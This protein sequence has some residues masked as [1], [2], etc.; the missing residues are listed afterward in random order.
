MAL[1]AGINSVISGF[2]SGIS[3]YY[4]RDARFFRVVIYFI[5]IITHVCDL[6]T[7]RMR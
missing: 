5:K 2:L 1:T 4:Y 7:H 6:I 3:L